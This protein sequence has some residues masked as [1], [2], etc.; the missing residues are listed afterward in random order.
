MCSRS[1]QQNLLGGMGAADLYRDMVPSGDQ[2]RTSTDSSAADS[3]GYL[4]GDPL[5]LQAIRQQPVQEQAGGF[6]SQPST[7][8]DFISFNQGVESFTTANVADGSTP[9]VSSSVPFQS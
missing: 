6:P 3:F 9:F 8:D 1:L 7:T 2:P 5:Q 4:S